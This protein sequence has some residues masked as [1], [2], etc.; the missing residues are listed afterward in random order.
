MYLYIL[1]FV[2]CLFMCIRILYLYI[3][4]TLN[5][6]WL[7]TLNKLL[8]VLTEFIDTLEV[9]L[10]DLLTDEEVQSKIVLPSQI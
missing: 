10:D 4:A 2:I 3:A 7:Y 8:Y 5:C 9:N 6:S 1:I